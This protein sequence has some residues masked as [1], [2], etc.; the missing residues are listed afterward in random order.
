MH[1]SDVVLH[2]LSSIMK[3]FAENASAR[4]ISSRLKDTVNP[5]DVVHDAIHN[6]SPSY[7]NYTHLKYE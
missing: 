3:F 7:Q 1:G 6:F 4:T 5:T 2:D